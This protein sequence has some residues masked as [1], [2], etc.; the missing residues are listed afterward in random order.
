METLKPFKNHQYQQLQD[1]YFE[2]HDHNVNECHEKESLN[3]ESG[4]EVAIV[5][6]DYKP[7]IDSHLNSI[8]EEKNFVTNSL[9]PPNKL[10][11]S[12]N[13]IYK[14]D[15]VQVAQKIDVEDL[16]EPHKKEAHC[17][18]AI[19][20]DFLGKTNLDLWKTKAQV[21]RETKTND[22]H[23]KVLHRNRENSYDFFGDNNLDSW[24]NKAQIEK[25]IDQ[26]GKYFQFD[27]S[28]DIFP[29]KSIENIPQFHNE[30]LGESSQRLNCETNTNY[31]YNLYSSRRLFEL[32]ENV[33]KCATKFNF[34]NTKPSQV[35]TSPNFTLN[36]PKIKSDNLRITS[37]KESEILN[38][39]FHLN[40][41]IHKP[42]TNEDVKFDDTICI[43]K[44]D[45][46]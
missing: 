46:K 45:N 21:E 2:N 33:T 1:F 18:Q 9:L 27:I 25:N 26:K 39:S 8:N 29:S 15:M 36:V 20:Y 31:A 12:H 11:L 38:N 19:S 43:L 37:S 44:G 28:K 32:E 30:T 34:E 13:G 24:E 10:F 7:T 16:N 14:T 3:I 41:D 5:D 17:M 40:R 42:I 22:L 6:G 35:V 23:K 4:L